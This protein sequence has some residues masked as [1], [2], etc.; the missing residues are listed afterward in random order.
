[1]TRLMRR[2]ALVGGPVIGA[3]AG[4]LLWTLPHWQ[5]ARWQGAVAD[6]QLLLV[7]IGGALL[8]A[9]ALLWRKVAAAERAALGA[10]ALAEDGQR[11]QRYT[12]AVVQLADERLEVRLGAIYTFER[13]AAE[14]RV[15]RAP[16]VEVL[17]AYVRRRA[18]WD[19][20][21]RKPESPSQDVQA[22]LTVL[23]RGDLS[24]EADGELRLDLRRCDLRGADLNGLQLARAIL[25]EAHLEGASLQGVHLAGA[26]LRGA[27]LNN[28]DLVEAD[29]KDADL[30]Q[31]HLEAAYLVDAHLEGA[32]L[33][34][35]FM[36]GAYLGGAYLQGA[37]L[38]GAQLDGAYLYKA[39]LD[40]VS[41]QGAR[42][43]SA[44]GVRRDE[45]ER[46][47]R[48]AAE[49]EPPAVTAV[50]KTVGAGRRPSRRE[51]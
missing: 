20:E 8:V 6:G 14:S 26:D 18:A 16:I 15:H 1:M 37:D 39:Q 11:L 30:R 49:L 13:L 5:T 31:A 32:N 43:V 45:R 3:A 29:L 34:G 27:H 33:G 25:H 46:I 23:G 22:V 44:I 41:L 12:S 9:L 48:T 28:A 7:V 21:K 24:D 35:A 38:G 2:I 40:G 4:A 50:R 51:L 36:A 10:R 47:N 42:M 19:A 17:C